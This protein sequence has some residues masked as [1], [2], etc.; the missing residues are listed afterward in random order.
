MARNA[1]PQQRWFWLAVLLSLSLFGACTL[2]RDGSLPAGSYQL[3]GTVAGL[4]GELTLFGA[5]S[6]I[7]LTHNDSFVF[8]N[9]VPNG[10]SY[11]VLVIGHPDGQRCTVNNGT[12]VMA[13]ADATNVAISC[14]SHPPFTIGGDVSGLGG[15]LTLWNGFETLVIDQDGPFVFPTRLTDETPYSVQVIIQPEGQRCEVQGGAGTVAGENVTSVAVT[16]LSDDT[17]LSDLAV[18]A[19]ALEPPFAPTTAIYTVDL[20]VWAQGL[21]VTPTTAHPAA[22]VTVAGLAVESGEAADPVALDLGSNIITITV[23]AESGA[24]RD[25][26]LFASR[27]DQLAYDYFKASNTGQ[28]DLFG[29]SIAL[30][31]DTLAVGAPYEDSST[32]GVGGIESDNG[33]HDAGAVYVFTRVGETWTQQAYIKA[34][35]T[36]GGDSFGYSLAL[37]GD[38]LVVGAPYEDSN[39]TGVGNDQTDDSAWDAGAVYVFARSGTD[40]WQEAYI[41]ASNT[42]AYD[43][44]GYDVALT[45]DTLVAGA[46]YEDSGATGVSATQSDNG[47]QNSGAVYVFTRTG[48]TWTQEV[49]IKPSNTDSHDYF[50]FSVAAEDDLLAVGALY[51]DGNATGINGDHH[52]NSATDSGAAYLFERS[53]S[54]T[55]QAYVKASNTETSDYFGTA[56]ALS[57]NTLAVGAHG[58]DSNALGV[59]GDQGDNSLADSGAAYVFTRVNNTWSQH[60]YLK[61]S[62]PG[63][64]DHFGRFLDV[65]GDTL[66]VGAPYEDSGASGLNGNQH[67]NS[68]AEAGALYVFSRAAGS[69][70]QEA[71]IKALNTNAADYFGYAVSLSTDALAV[72]APY[73]NSSATGVNGDPYN[74]STGDSGAAYLIR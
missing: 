1:R 65:R 7:T 13:S 15:V 29:Y 17:L 54:W 50:G 59:N 11:D 18:S 30:S 42:D 56:V 25:T 33:A 16:C 19:G 74:N 68:S 73:E 21:S 51:E 46:P 24:T 53:G 27:A 58:E 52:D 48:S 45:G 43:S 4:D 8:P 69:W 63:G 2:N 10:T 39:T 40:W 55:Q 32:T 61:A 6:A 70:G 22:T 72:G 71:Y 23:T 62:N 49:Y 37:S 31:G 38:T 67:D 5:G 57:G 34:S 9:R 47:A 3:G 41:K 36:D 20:G 26:T 28:S 35:N 14:E 44:F 60:A 12:G 66:A 64:V